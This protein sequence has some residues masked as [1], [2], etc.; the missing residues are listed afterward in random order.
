VEHRVDERQGT[1]RELTVLLV[2]L[3]VDGGRR[4][5]VSSVGKTTAENRGS[6]SR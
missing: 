1:K 5:T 2:G 4:S 6:W 3:E